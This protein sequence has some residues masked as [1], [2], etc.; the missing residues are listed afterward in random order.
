MSVCCLFI[1]VCVIN[2]HLQ[3]LLGGGR[4]KFI[5]N[6]AMDEEGQK[7]ERHDGE[8]LIEQW[9]LDKRKREANAR[10]VWN[11][12]QL[13]HTDP[14]KTDYLLGMSLFHYIKV[15][16]KRNGTWTAAWKLLT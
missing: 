12:D 1:Y 3:V 7:G 2:I 5:P 10:Y 8:N 13:L 14:T 4:S 9:K 16:D 11:R 15:A 6:N